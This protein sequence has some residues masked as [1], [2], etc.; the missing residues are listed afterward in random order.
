MAGIGGKLDNPDGI[1]TAQLAGTAKRYA[2][3]GPLVVDAALAELWEMAG[4]RCRLLLGVRPLSCPQHATEPVSWVTDTR[5]TMQV[6]QR[7]RRNASRSA[8]R[9]PDQ[10]VPPAGEQH[11]VPTLAGHDTEAEHRLR[12][13]PVTGAHPSASQIVGGELDHVHDAPPCHL[14]ATYHHIRPR[15]NVGY[16]ASSHALTMRPR[17]MNLAESG[18]RPRPRGIA[19][20]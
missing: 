18:Q 10:L 12:V 8:R 3:R 7:A 15:S 9:R 17:C 6:P 11:P 4:G 13:R 2:S 20:Q 14:A 16:Q 1:I 5:M 19:W